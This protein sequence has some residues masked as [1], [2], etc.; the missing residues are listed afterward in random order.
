[1]CTVSSVYGFWKFLRNM[2]DIFPEH[3]K[4]H[5]NESVSINRENLPNAYKL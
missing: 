1:M 5:A 3:R 2:E 4:N